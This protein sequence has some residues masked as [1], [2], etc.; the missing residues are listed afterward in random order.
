MA[1]KQKTDIEE[2][3]EQALALEQQIEKMESELMANEKFVQFLELKKDV[4]KKSKELFDM[5]KERMI[6]TDRKTVK[7][8]W[9]S[10]TLAERTTWYGDVDELPRKF[11]KKVPDSKKIA[12]AYTLEGKA[13]KGATSKTTKYLTKRFK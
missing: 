11:V 5:I 2:S 12:Q 9:G 8:D 6:E 3:V 4:E 10:I 13:P 1:T 7:G